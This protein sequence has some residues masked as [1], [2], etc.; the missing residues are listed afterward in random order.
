MALTLSIPCGLRAV[1]FHAIVKIVLYRA[2]W[3]LTCAS[4][5][6]NLRA[7]QRMSC[8]RRRRGNFHDDGCIKLLLCILRSARH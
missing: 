8:R 2:F 5:G 7:P 4:R 3:V 1:S 6:C